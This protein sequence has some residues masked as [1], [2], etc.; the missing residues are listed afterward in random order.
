MAQGSHF[1][2]HDNDV[3]AN[4]AEACL[5]RLQELNPTVKCRAVSASLSEALVHA[6]DVVVLVGHSRAEASAVSAWARSRSPAPARVCW[7]S[8]NGLFG[9]VCNDFGAQFDVL[10]TTGENPRTAVIANIVPNGDETLVSCVDD[11]RIDFEEGD[12]VKLVEIDGMDGIDEVEFTVKDVQ[13]TSFKIGSTTQF[14]PYKNGGTVVQQKQPKTIEFAPIADAFTAFKGELLETDFS[15]F[16]RAR[17][18]MLAYEALE[19]LR[20][21]NG[22]MLPALNDADAAA[23]LVERAAQL[24]A[25][26]AEDARVDGL[27][28]AKPLLHA[29][30]LTARAVL[31][32][33]AA[34]FGGIVGQE[35][36]KAAT[37]KFHPI[38]QWLLFDSLESNVAVDDPTQRDAFKQPEPTRYEHQIAVFGKDVQQK[39]QEARCVVLCCVFASPR[40]RAVSG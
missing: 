21:E 29:L 35:V 8:V 28:D 32:P 15:K 36:I 39:L 30:A 3:G 10:D 25:A 13:K 11:E 37:G 38:H 26:R 6:H 23:K 34:F 2:L 4:R 24:N 12:I 7:T 22:N 33:M 1:Y 19:A 18:L 14:S 31:N 20:A 9:F 16:G 5:A 17:L 40:A 27:D